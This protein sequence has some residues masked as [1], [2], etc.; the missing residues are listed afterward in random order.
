MLLF[1]ALLLVLSGFIPLSALAKIQI[2]TVDT[3]PYVIKTGEG[4]EG[5]SGEFGKAVA[6]SIK[7]AGK[8]QEFEVVWV[9][10][11]RALLDVEKN[12]QSLFFPLGR[13]FEREYKYHWVLHLDDVDCLL[14]AVDPKVQIDNLEDLRKYRIGVQGGSAREQE[15]HRYVGKSSKV[16]A[17]SDD[18]SNFRKLQTGRIDI[19]ATRPM[20][21]DEA[22]RQM[23]AKGM[24]LRE[25]RVVKK[26][27]TQSLWLVGNRDMSDQSRNLVQSIFGWGNKKN[28]VK[29]PALN[30]GNFLNGALL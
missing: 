23:Q 9:P 6:T 12:P 18:L 19:W 14:Y 4:L 3:P 22:K 15:L 8:Q 16:E 24:P 2:Y 25:V 10:Y 11:K 26:L 30:A 27:F 20:F 5:L 21:V 13:S 29:S 28:T 17:M 7:K 1:C